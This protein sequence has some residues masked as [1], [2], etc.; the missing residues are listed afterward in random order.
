[1]SGHLSVRRDRRAAAVGQRGAALLTALLIV[2]L[3]TTLAA[4]MLWR[5]ARSIQIEAAERGRAQADWVLQGALDWARLIL[6]EDKRANQKDNVDHLGEVW[7]VPLAEARLSSFL[8]TDENKSADAGPDAFL[9]GRIEDAQA[10]FNLRNVVSGKAEDLRAAARIFQAAG[11]TGSLAQQ[12][13]VRLS[14][15]VTPASA[16]QGDVPLLP[17]RLEQLRW[18]GLSDEQITRLGALAVILPQQT[19]VNVN[20]ASREVLAALFDGMDIGS[21]D[22]IVRA[23]QAKPFRTL[24]ELKPYLPLGVEASVERSAF[25]SDFYF[26]EGQLRM[27]D[28]VLAQRSLVHRRALEIVV[29]DRQRLQRQAGRAGNGGNGG[30]GYGASP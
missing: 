7:S 28:R 26:V 16:P 15:A 9:S 24:E 22:R 8:S 14:Y 19:P 12:L 17:I 3:V 25:T 5:Q 11:L 10:R 18:L 29:L 1:M 6:R 13:Q 4:A 27:D 20:T 21:A 2:T 23:R 30:N